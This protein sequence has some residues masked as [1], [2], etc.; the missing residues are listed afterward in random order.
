MELN[1]FSYREVILAGSIISAFVIAYVMI[2]IIIRVSKLKNLLDDPSHRKV[3]ISA[4]PNLGGAA[5]YAA[6]LVP[7]CMAGY[8][9]SPWG[10]TLIAGL[11]IL[12]FAGMKDDIFVIS[13]DRKLLLQGVAIAALIFGGDVLITD[14]G[15]VFGINTIGYF[16]SVGITF[17]T[18]V[19]VLNAFNLIDGIDGLAGGIGI[20][21]SLF[22]GS[23]FYTAGLMDY[24]ALAFIL[25]ASLAGFL[26][27]NFEPAKIFMGDTGSQIVGYLLAFFA[28]TFVDIGVANPAMPFH[29]IVPV[30]VL[31]VLIVPLYDTL[32]V[33]IVRMVRGHSPFHADRRHV[34]HQLIDYGFSHWSACLV[35]YSFNLIIIG[36]TL[37]LDG[38]DINLLFAAVL[39]STVLLFPT[40]R[41]KRRILS[42]MNVPI[43]TEQQI[44][45]LENKLTISNRTNDKSPKRSNKREKERREIT[46]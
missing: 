5:I 23:W 17:F 31:S 44:T 36:L 13:W 34:H 8:A 24:A 19:V 35:I 41:F 14:F 21:A 32:R 6:V 40:G 42:A 33:F 38:L 22:F 1:V 46:V 7:F 30:L 25:A 20:L 27:Y 12:F 43:P 16:T 11:T 18:M 2:P 9:A 4:I 39:A 29:G 15:G 37:L 45:D 26:R 28:V 10:G 3:H